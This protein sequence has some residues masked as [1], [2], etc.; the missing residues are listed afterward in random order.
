MND[1]LP[2]IVVANEAKQ[3]NG[4]TGTALEGQVR[5]RLSARRAVAIFF[6]AI[7]LIQALV[8]LLPIASEWYLVQASIVSRTMPKWAYVL[9]FLAGLQFVYSYL[10]NRI[11]DWSSLRVTSWVLVGY[12]CAFVL[13][14]SGLIAGGRG[15]TLS[16]LLQ[17]TESLRPRAVVWTLALTCINGLIAT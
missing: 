4:A 12:C 1:E 8:T 6:S 17:I 14:A 10:L 16:A 11:P 5:S 7:L 3:F 13:V 9:T 15:G 2:H